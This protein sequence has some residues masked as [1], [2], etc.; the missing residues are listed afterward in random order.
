MTM[1]FLRSILSAA[2]FLMFG[3]GGVLFSFLLLFPVPKPCARRILRCL[4]RFFVWAGEKVRLFDVAISDDDRRRLGAVSGVV[5][6]ANHQTLIDAVIL[7]SLLGDSVCVTKEAVSR[8]PFMRV[9]ARKILIVNEGPVSVVRA[10]AKYLQSGVNVVVFPE[11]TRTP[12]DAPEHVFRRG[13]AHI[14]IQSGSP[15]ETISMR[16][17]LAILAKNQPWWDVGCRTAVYSVE[18]RGRI[19]PESFSAPA[20]TAKESARVLTLQMHKEIFG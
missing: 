14:A 17:N 6:V 10:A 5:V 11:G 2:F 7:I 15:V 3:A 19:V 9:V 8:N 1:R 12:A 13:A 18:C 16:C 4:F 20:M